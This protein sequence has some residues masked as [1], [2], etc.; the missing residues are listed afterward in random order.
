MGI[1][2]IFLI[3]GPKGM[4]ELHG[5]IAHHNGRPFADPDLGNG[6]HIHLHTHRP[7]KNNIHPSFQLQ[8]QDRDFL[9][10]QTKPNKTILPAFRALDT[11]GQRLPTQ[12]LEFHIQVI[13]KEGKQ[14]TTHCY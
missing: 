9:K 14:A 10:N 2:L 5:K 12:M 6:L 3:T 4:L 13:L 11:D 7:S 8:A 1:K